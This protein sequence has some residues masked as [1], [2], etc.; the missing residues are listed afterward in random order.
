[1]ISASLEGVASIFSEYFIQNP[2][3]ILTVTGTGFP[4]DVQQSVTKM[5]TL[6][7]SQI[8]SFDSFYRRFS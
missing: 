8:E 2:N 5:Q 7:I 1:M 6:T 3:N 4:I